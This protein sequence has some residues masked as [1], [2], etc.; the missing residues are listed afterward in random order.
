MAFVIRLGL[1]W[2]ALL[3]LA[4]C[5][6]NDFNAE[7]YAELDQRYDV[8]IRRDVR[9][10][11][12]VLGATDPDTAFGFAYA[13]AEDNWQLIEDAMPFYRGNSAV[14]SG[15]DGAV[16]DYLVKWLGLWET[17]HELSLIHI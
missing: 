5:Q 8:V 9:G 12:H 2:F 11:P 4:G 7:S 3:A 17:V 16:T 6:T 13:Q 15:M 1:C 14:Y 10:V